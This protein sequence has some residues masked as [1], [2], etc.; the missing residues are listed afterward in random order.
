MDIVYPVIYKVL[1]IPGKCAGFLNHQL[2]F[3]R[4]TLPETNKSL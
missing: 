4:N 3:V 1:H 2:I